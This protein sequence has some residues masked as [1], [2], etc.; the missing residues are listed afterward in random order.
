MH[1]QVKQ[2]VLINSFY[3]ENYT[4]IC[5]INLI[6]TSI[7]TIGSQRRLF[8]RSVGFRKH[9]S[10]N[11]KNIKREFSIAYDRKVEFAK[12]NLQYQAST[13][14]WRFAEHPWDYVGDYNKDVSPTYNGWIDI[15][16]WGSGNDP[17]QTSHARKY[18]KVFNDWGNNN[19]INGDGKHWRTLT[20]DEWDY[21]LKKRPTDSGI[22]FVCA[23]VCGIEG[24]IILPDNWDK[25]ICQ[26]N[27]I[28]KLG[29]EIVNICE[30][31]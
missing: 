7:C 2:I 24:V 14:T 9:H 10:Y 19:I 25:S 3:E 21:V 17:I 12:G 23:S 30:S 5:H 27:E 8:Q 16:G 28:N 29:G 11:K 22:R 15:F 18:Y 26:L 20:K 6:N 31:H 1:C 13:N 4:S